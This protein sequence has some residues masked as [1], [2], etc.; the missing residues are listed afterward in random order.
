MSLNT[1]ETPRFPH[2]CTR[3]TF[4][5]RST[6]GE[7]DLYHCPQP[8]SGLGPTLVWRAG[9]RGEDYASMPVRL[10][11]NLTLGEARCI[12][13]LL[14][15]FFLAMSRGLLRGENGPKSSLE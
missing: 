6:I 3:C 12:P 9:S 11:L 5:G 4:L 8:D 2:D 15:A 1:S 13:G 14:E 7:V 10:V